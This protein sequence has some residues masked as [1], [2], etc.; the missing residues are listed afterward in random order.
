MAFFQWKERFNIGNAEIDRQ[1]RS[2]LEL[3]NKYYESGSGGTKDEIGDTLIVS[4]REYAVMH[5]RFEE[6][7]MRKTGY[8]DVEHQETQ[9]RYFES[10]VTTLE[11][12]HRE[13][14]KDDSKVVLSMLKDW[15]LRHILEEDRK[16][17]STYRTAQH[18]Q[19]D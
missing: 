11:S 6:Q 12:H 7:L 8:K 18:A 3:L 10:L 19:E 2:F 1:H 17:T 14:K 9:H 13:G 16:F 4:I 15:F 5:F